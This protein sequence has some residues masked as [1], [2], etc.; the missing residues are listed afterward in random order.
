M[1]RFPTAFISHSDH[2]HAFVR[3]LVNKLEEYGVPMWFDTL[4]LRA[5]DS[6]G[7]KIKSSIKENDFLIV[8]LSEK[9]VDSSWVC[10][11]LEVGLADELEHRSIKV[12]PALLSDCKI[13]DKLRDKYYA[14]F[15]DEKKFYSGI[16]ELLRGICRDHEVFVLRLAPVPFYIEQKGLADA[17]KSLMDLTDQ[18]DLN[19]ALSHSKYLGAN[20]KWIAILD[21]NGFVEELRSVI[22]LSEDYIRETFG[23]EYV[24]SCRADSAAFTF[25]LRN[26]G[27]ILP[28]YIN[29]ALAYLGKHVMSIDGVLQAVQN[30]TKIVVYWIGRRAILCCDNNRLSA[31]SS[32]DGE[33]FRSEIV[34]IDS[35]RDEEVTP[36]RCINVEIFG[37]D[38]EDLLYLGFRGVKDTSKKKLIRDVSLDVPTKAVL[39]DTL[40]FLYSFVHPLAPITE[41]TYSRW[42]EYFMP[43]IT[44]RHL[45]DFSYMCETTVS[46][47]K[48]KGVNRLVDCIGLQ[49]N[50]YDHF[51]LN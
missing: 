8:V 32:I 6:L 24:I 14:D 42:V 39:S 29:T 45:L 35:R 7:K 10:Q 33:K 15:R 4:E 13:P 40:E 49:L 3:K 21:D 17:L 27:L 18:R 34:R 20:P 41:I 9:S 46:Y 25:V 28:K 5:G 37:C 16:R 2:D 1:T 36:S 50:D 19:E 26:L 23:D 12:V 47:R 44:T 38:F 30:L 48:G 51:G 22:S 31:M 43:L 11:E